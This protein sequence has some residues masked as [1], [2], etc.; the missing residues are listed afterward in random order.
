M[1]REHL[2]GHP[3]DVDASAGFGSPYDASMHKG[4]SFYAKSLMA[5]ATLPTKVQV[6]IS[7]KH[8][9][10][11]SGS[12]EAGATSGICNQ[13]ASSGL[14]EC[15]NDFFQIVDITPTWAQYTV[16][17]SNIAT[18]TWAAAYTKGQIDPTT[19]YHVHWQLNSLVPNFDIQLACISWVD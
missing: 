7:D 17:F 18:A 3:A 15:A 12:P 2:H 9:D 13:C 14:T 11:G 10:P 4:I 6:Q 8:T 1:P 16:L 19:L 5:T